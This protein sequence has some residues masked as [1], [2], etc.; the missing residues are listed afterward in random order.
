MQI[1]KVGQPI[2]GPENKPLLVEPVEVTLDCPV[3]Y[4]N[5]GVLI[6][7]T[8]GIRCSK[9][10]AET[11]LHVL[12]E[13]CVKYGF[14]LVHV[15]FYNA[16]YARKANGKPIVPQRWSNHSR[17]LAIDWK[18]VKSNGVFY[19]VSKLKTDSPKKYEEFVGGC[20][21]AIKAAGRRVEIV[22]EIGWQ[23]LGLYP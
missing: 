16:R 3:F 4:D 13:V 6:R 12:E 23:H 19:S 11:V 1:K 14:G 9:V 15:G 20:R 2:G 17:G 8:S 5:D 10:F 7:Q 21:A 22:Y 18:G